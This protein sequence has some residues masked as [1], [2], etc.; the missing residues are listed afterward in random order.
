MAELLI[1]NRRVHKILNDNGLQIFDT[2]I[3]NFC[4]SQEMAGFSISL[5]KL[6]EELKEYYRLPVRSF[7]LTKGVIA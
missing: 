7:A 4:T 5:M 1:I 6:D 3:G 2:L